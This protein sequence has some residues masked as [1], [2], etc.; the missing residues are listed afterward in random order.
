M[1]LWTLLL[2]GMYL[3]VLCL[4]NRFLLSDV[5]SFEMS[6]PVDVVRC[7]VIS[8]AGVNLCRDQIYVMKTSAM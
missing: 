4:D 3:L 5:S 2:T 6:F 1:Q 7:A 8:S